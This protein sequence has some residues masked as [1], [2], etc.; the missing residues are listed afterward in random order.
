MT[1]QLDATLIFDYD[2]GDAR[3][4]IVRR[5]TLS[6]SLSI[7]ALLCSVVFGL[8]LLDLYTF[9]TVCSAFVDRRHLVVGH[10]LFVFLL[11]SVRPVDSTLASFRLVFRSLYV[12]V[13][14][15]QTGPHATRNIPA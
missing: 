14:I 10:Y 7:S 5:Y 9:P 13:K 12:T 4:F 3:R 2:H 1:T 8:A 11:L 15:H 6:L